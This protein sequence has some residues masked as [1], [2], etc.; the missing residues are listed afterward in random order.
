MSEA[1]FPV[2]ITRQGRLVVNSDY[3]PKLP[4]VFVVTAPRSGTHYVAALLREMNFRPS[5]LHAWTEGSDHVVQDRRR[6]YQTRYTTELEFK[7]YDLGLEDILPYMRQ[8]QVL[9]GHTAFDEKLASAMGD[10]RVV[11]VRRDMRHRIIS[12]MR[13]VAM[14]SSE[15]WAQ[16]PGSPEKI[17][18][19]LRAHGDGFIGTIEY[20]LPWARMQGSHVLDFDRSIA[21]TAESLAEFEALRRF[22]NVSPAGI[23]P[24]ACLSAAR[25]SDTTSWTGRLSSVA[26]LWSDEVE[27]EYRARKLDVLE[28][29]EKALQ[30]QS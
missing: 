29:E 12:S 11:Y 2:Y 26:D 7:N 19:Y 15:D 17:V 27:A 22:L 30:T 14:F 13:F 8:G 28:A 25:N 20:L 18:Q 10:F 16:L 6:F 1:N 4:K 5:G 21:G 9:Q 3:N 23:D 24:Q